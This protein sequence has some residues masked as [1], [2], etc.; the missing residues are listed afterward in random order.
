[1]KLL[2]LTPCILSGVLAFCIQSIS[3]KI[4]MAQSVSM[5]GSPGELSEELVT[6]EKR[7]KSWR[8]KCDVISPTS[9]LILQPFR[10]FTYVTAHS[11]ILPLL[12]LRHSS[13]S[14]LLSLLRRHRLFTYVTWRAPHVN[15]SIRYQALNLF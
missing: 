13:F 12:H 14:T 4:K 10:R 3:Y 5:G 1:M 7:K 9:Q 8:M 2:S 15:W 6:Q 11:S